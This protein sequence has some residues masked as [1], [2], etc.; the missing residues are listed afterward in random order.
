MR[1][2]D[3][4]G[5]FKFAF[6]KQGRS[7][8]F[9]V[10]VFH[11]VFGYRADIKPDAVLPEAIAQAFDHGEPEVRTG[12][13]SRLNPYRFRKMRCV[14]SLHAKTSDQTHDIIKDQHLSHAVLITL[15]KRF[16]P[17]GLWRIDGDSS[18][19]EAFAMGNARSIFRKAGYQPEMK[20]L[21]EIAEVSYLPSPHTL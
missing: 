1:H 9:Y 5:A 17:R 14:V 13:L 20:F 3:A 6:R 16:N 21:K 18:L 19:A 8:Q 11:T 2:L 4:R 10:P 12:A 15:S 7:T